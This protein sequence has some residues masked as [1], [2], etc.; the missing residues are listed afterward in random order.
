[1]AGFLLQVETHKSFFVKHTRNSC[2]AFYPRH[3]HTLSSATKK[4][5]QAYRN[6]ESFLNLYCSFLAGLILPARS[7]GFS[8]FCDS[9]PEG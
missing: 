2:F 1:M 4:A 6:N 8:G 9:C 5:E 3:L 7:N